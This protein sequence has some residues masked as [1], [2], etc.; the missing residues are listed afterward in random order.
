MPVMTGGGIRRRP[1][2]GE[3]RRGRFAPS[4]AKTATTR[5]NTAEV[6]DATMLSLFG[7]IVV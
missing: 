4:S 6:F 2:S 5:E 1:E 3:G 7:N